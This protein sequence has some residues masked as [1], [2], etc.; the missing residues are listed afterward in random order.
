MSDNNPNTTNSPTQPV[1][2]TRP[3]SRTRDLVR[4]CDTVIDQYH[5]GL[6]EKSEALASI[7]RIIPDSTIIG[8]Q[9]FDAFSQY[10]ARLEEDDKRNRSAAERGRQT[11]SATAD[12]NGSE[13]E[14]NPADPTD[15][16]ESSPAN[17]Q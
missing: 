5:S 9:G 4:T 11:S 2:S 3:S 14:P 15:P 12:T 1:H 16:N 8:T 17:S 6:L 10:V 13:R 7:V